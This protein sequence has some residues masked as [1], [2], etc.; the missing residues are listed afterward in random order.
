MGRPQSHARLLPHLGRPAILNP[1]GTM[2]LVVL[3]TLF[4]NLPAD[5]AAN[6]Y[7]IAV[8][9]FAQPVETEED[10]L[11]QPEIPWPA[12]WNEPRKLPPEQSGLYNAYDRLRRSRSFRPML[13]TAW[14]QA[15]G[16]HR[17]NAPYHVGSTDG[18]VEGVVRLQRGEY[19]HVIVD[20]EYRAP[21]GIIHRL[22]EKRRVKFNEIHYLDHPAFGV[23][24]RVSP[25]DTSQ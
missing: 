21:D 20:M 3:L 24:I 15:A 19:L 16:P 11:N 23:L 9:A 10:L 1:T 2:R 6:R 7:Q 4:W 17:I 18:P 14:I 12:R 25:V 8:V 22:R 13:H 5:A